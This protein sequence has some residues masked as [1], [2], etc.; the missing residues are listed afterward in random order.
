[1][2]AVDI[3]KKSGLDFKQELGYS[4]STLGSSN[5]YLNRFVE[6]ETHLKKALEIFESV[7]SPSKLRVTKVNL[8]YDKRTPTGLSLK[9]PF[10]VFRQTY[11]KYKIMPLLDTGLTVDY[12]SIL[13]LR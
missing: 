10:T 4:L 13:K 12:L 9:L 2:R 3:H 11:R 6:A 8:Y 5:R 7:D 1:M